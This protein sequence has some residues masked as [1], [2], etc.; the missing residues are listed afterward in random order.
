MR[1]AIHHAADGD[2]IF[3]WD[4]TR[5]HLRAFVIGHNLCQPDE[6]LRLP[7]YRLNRS[8]DAFGIVLNTDYACQTCVARWHEHTGQEAA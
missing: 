4:E 2:H 8:R 5:A 1:H 6:T 7:Y 3:T